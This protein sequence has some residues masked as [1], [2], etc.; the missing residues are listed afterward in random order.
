M[1]D[2]VEYIN[3][4]PGL[5]K[6]GGVDEKL[7]DQAE[8]EL[9][10]KFAQDY[11]DYTKA[12]GRIS[13]FGVELTGVVDNENQDVRKMTL[14]EREY[15]NLIPDDMYV[16]EE[17]GMES[18]IYLQNRLGTVFSSIGHSPPKPAFSSLIDYLEEQKR[19]WYLYWAR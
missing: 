3:G 19:L 4:L 2:I 6:S 1:S 15:N 11:R 5:H 17:T 14:F 9:G 13:V 7:I 12:F 10:L 18:L 16:I 8:K